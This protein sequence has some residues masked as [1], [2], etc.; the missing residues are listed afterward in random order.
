[1]LGLFVAHGTGGTLG[2]MGTGAVLVFIGVAMYSSRIVPRLAEWLGWPSTRL[3]GAV[4]ALARDNARRNPQRTASTA[5]ALMI[6]L[7]LR[8]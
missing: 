6:G 7:A 1:V 8:S 2:L 5:S 3:A 4:G